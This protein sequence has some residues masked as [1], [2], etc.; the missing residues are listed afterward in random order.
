MYDGICG[1]LTFLL[2]V[3]VTTPLKYELEIANQARAL[4]ILAVVYF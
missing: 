2:S 3:G 4:E 1:L